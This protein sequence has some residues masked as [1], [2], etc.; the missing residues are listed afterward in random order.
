[1]ARRRKRTDQSSLVDPKL[2]ALDQRTVAVQLQVMGQKRVLLGRGAYERDPDQ[3]AVLRIRFD[4][5]PD[6]EILIQEAH[7]SGKILP[8]KDVGCDYLIE[9]DAP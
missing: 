1:M 7:W 2:S 3:G 4:T 6:S 5:D 8:G 9:L